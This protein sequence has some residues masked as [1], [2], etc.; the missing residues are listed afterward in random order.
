MADKAK[1]LIRTYEPA[2]DAK[3]FFGSLKT[4]WAEIFFPGMSSGICLNATS[5]HSFAKSF[6]VISGS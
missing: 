1:D 3:G 4:A 2:G 6:S 5:S